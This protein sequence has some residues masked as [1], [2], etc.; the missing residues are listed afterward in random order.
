[1]EGAR[2]PGQWPA[3]PSAMGRPLPALVA[4]VLKDVCVLF[5]AVPSPPGPV[6]AG[7]RACAHPSV[8]SCARHVWGVPYSLVEQPA[9]SH[10]S[11]DLGE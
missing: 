7:A 1:M 9:T 6:K 3:A 11:L 4:L 2:V 5:L 8:P 10:P